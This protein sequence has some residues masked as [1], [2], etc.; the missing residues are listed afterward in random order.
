MQPLFAT[1]LLNSVIKLIDV[2]TVYY[3]WEVKTVLSFI[4]Q[5]RSICL[6]IERH[7]CGQTS[8]PDVGLA[9]QTH[10]NINASSG[11]CSMLLVT[12]CFRWTSLLI[13]KPA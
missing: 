6:Y 12:G 4:L 13:G 1:A 8:R 3:L 5:V 2:K 11:N 9:I 7:K 10:R